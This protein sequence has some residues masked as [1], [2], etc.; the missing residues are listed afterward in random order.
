MAFDKECNTLD[1]IRRQFQGLA[2]GNSGYVFGAGIEYDAGTATI[3]VDIAA[4]SGLEFVAAELAVNVDE[5]SALVLSASGIQ[6]NVDT[7]YGLSIDAAAGVRIDLLGTGGLEFSGGDLAI[8][9]DTDPGLVLAASGLKVLLPA[10][11]GLVLGATGLIVDIGQS[12]SILAIDATGLI[13]QFLTV[14]GAAGSEAVILTG[15]TTGTSRMRY[16]ATA[17]GQVLVNSTTVTLQFW[18]ASAGPEQVIN[19]TG[20]SFDNKTGN[21]FTVYNTTGGSLTGAIDLNATAS[22]IRGFAGPI[23]VQPQASSAAAG[24]ACT[25]SGGRGKNGAGTGT[26]SG[27][28]VAS[29]TG[30]GGA[31]TVAGGIALGTNQA[32]GTTTIKSGEPTGTGTS[33]LLLQSVAAGGAAT[34]RIQI[35]LTGIGFFGATPIA[36]PGTYTITAAP[37]VATALNADA[38]GGAAYTGI[39]TASITDLND[40]RADV[41]SLAAVVRQLIRHLGD[42]AGL[43]IVDETGY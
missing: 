6:V 21:S 28:D 31:A 16:G 7:D 36:R 8:N 3:S 29:G 22:S 43:G 32:G 23:T 17:G 33:S 24:S 30:A 2:S 25:V 37:A 15:G 38:N 9:L 4:N 41:Q 5:A 1:R 13:T 19:T 18:S 11:S 26:L 40:L 39:G 35:N 12:P 27:G 14:S 10:T 20:W 42:T 34:T